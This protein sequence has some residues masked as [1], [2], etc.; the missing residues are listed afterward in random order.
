MRILILSDAN[1]THTKRWVSA[2]SKKHNIFLFSPRP[3]P[4]SDN[5]YSGLDNV[6]VCAFLTRNNKK[7]IDNWRYIY[8]IPFLKQKIKEF[9]PDILHSHFVSS[10]GVLGALTGFHP[11]ITSAWGSDIYIKPKKSPLHKALVKY[12]LK[13]AD[14]ILSTS[15]I[16]SKEI[17]KY[18]SKDTE[19]TPFGVDTNLFRK[20]EIP[21]DNDTFVIGNIK[22]LK[23]IYGIDILIKAYALVKANNHNLNSQLIIIGDGPYKKNYA[24]LAASLGIAENVNFLGALPNNTLTKHYNNFDIAVFPSISE[25]FGVVAIEAMACECPVIASDADGFTEVII[26]NKTG[27]IVPK[28]NP[29]ALA[30]A[31]QKYIDTPTLKQ[32]HGTE[33]RKRVLELYD[34]EDNVRRVEEI[35]KSYE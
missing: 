13:N 8:C 24:N 20:I 31:I 6:E 9:Q 28:G 5:Y 21:K 7:F 25:S 35:Y 16:L 32:E 10:Y 17:A 27:I 30:E 22:S 29:E 4:T 3:L 14:K 1:S 26:N 19:I 23:P 15:N 18:T 12:A 34:W 11:H 33:G 2:L